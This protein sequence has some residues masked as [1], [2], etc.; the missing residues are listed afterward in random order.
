MDSSGLRTVLSAQRE[1][2]ARES[3]L[4]IVEP[5]GV[6]LRLFTVSG[7]LDHFEIVELDR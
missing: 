3:L 5:S 4:T 2:H 7:L 1:L 6:V